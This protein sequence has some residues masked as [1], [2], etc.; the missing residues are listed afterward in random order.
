MKRFLIALTALAATPALAGTYTATPVS[1]PEATKIIARDIAWT[2]SGGVFT[3]RTEQSRP[4]VL[5]QGLA[6]RT[7]RLDRFAVNGVAFGTEELA[8]CNAFAKDGGT[9]LA[10]AD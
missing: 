10:K 9:A 8:K 7:G 2:Y 6:K 4:M 5:C 1:Q 3:G